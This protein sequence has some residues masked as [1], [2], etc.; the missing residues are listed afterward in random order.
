MS[1]NMRKVLSAHDKCVNATHGINGILA[2]LFRQMLSNLKVDPGKWNS[3]MYD[4]VTDPRNAVPMNRKDQTSARGNIAKELFRP[5]MTWK[6]FC[7]GLR[8]LH[9]VR[10]EIQIVAYHRV[11]HPTVH[12]TTVD[13]GT[14]VN[15]TGDDSDDDE[16]Q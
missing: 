4:Y 11:G 13:L 1:D 16:S 9:I 15:D 7:K 6:V 5:Q 10:F 3:L 14:Q 2:R 8:L 12:S